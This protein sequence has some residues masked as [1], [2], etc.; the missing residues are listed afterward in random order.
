MKKLFVG[1][2]VAGVAVCSLAINYNLN[3][4]NKSVTQSQASFKALKDRYE[5][6]Y[7]SAVRAKY[8][9]CPVYV[10]GKP[11]LDILGQPISIM[12]T[13]PIHLYSSEI[14]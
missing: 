7:S 14:K 2:V 5:Q 12:A 4:H 3:T 1:L 6:T 13:K 11:E 10:N 8:H 9:Y